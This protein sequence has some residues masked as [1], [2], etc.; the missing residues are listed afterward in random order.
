MDEKKYLSGSGGSLNTIY[1]DTLLSL[2][3]SLSLSS[4]IGAL[5][6]P[7]TQSSRLGE[8]SELWTERDVEILLLRNRGIE[9]EQ[10]EEAIIDTIK[11]LAK[12]LFAA[13][14]QVSK[15]GL[16]ELVDVTQGVIDGYE[17]R[18][19]PSMAKKCINDTKIA[20]DLIG[21]VLTENATITQL[22]IRNILRIPGMVQLAANI[23]VHCRLDQL[24]GKIAALA[25]EVA[26][27]FANG[28]ASLALKEGPVLLFN[29]PTLIKDILNMTVAVTKLN[30]YG[31]GFAAGDIIAILL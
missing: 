2:S 26:S 31:V 25:V 18:A 17:T 23:T 9:S 24:V 15:F 1:I 3:L 27:A 21:T 11:N 22:A 29:G 20:R 13:F 4:V 19:N 7:I 5:I 12:P 30:F 10:R 14:K 8:E 28:G 6:V 16:K